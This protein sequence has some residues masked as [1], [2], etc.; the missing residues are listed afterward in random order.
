MAGLWRSIACLRHLLNKVWS[1]EHTVSR[2]LVSQ[3][4]VYELITIWKFFEKQ[5]MHRILSYTWVPFWPLF[6]IPILIQRPIQPHLH[7]QY[8]IHAHY[9][10]DLKTKAKINKARRGWVMKG[11]HD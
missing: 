3:T 2:H 6:I 5:Y 8:S 4:H 7:Y 11:R 1:H 9:I 10:F